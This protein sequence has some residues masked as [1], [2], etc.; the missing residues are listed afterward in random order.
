MAPGTTSPSNFSLKVLT[1]CFGEGIWVFL[2]VKKTSS[3]VCRK[4]DYNKVSDH[5][6]VDNEIKQHIFNFDYVEVS[7][8]HVPVLKCIIT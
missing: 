8:I 7:N 4:N 2:V 1:I 5:L 6:V 3:L